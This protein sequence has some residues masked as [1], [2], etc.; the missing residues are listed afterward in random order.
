M[1]KI[2]SSN[3]RKKKIENTQLLDQLQEKNSQIHSLEKQLKHALKN[4]NQEIHIRHNDSDK[5]TPTKKTPPSSHKPIHSE[6]RI[7]F[8][9]QSTPS[10]TD[11]ILVKNV[12]PEVISPKFATHFEPRETHQEDVSAA[13]VENQEEEGEIV[14]A[15]E[16][17]NTG[18]KKRVQKVSVDDVRELGY[19]LNMCLRASGITFEELDQTIWTEEVLK[20]NR[21]TIREMIEVLVKYKILLYYSS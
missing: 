14:Q 9:T 7:I 2:S 8:D 15:E 6:P 13:D 20:R 1:E 16:E 12:E 5:S 19:E 4:Q 17:K 21:I 18:P 10:K 3:S 11:P